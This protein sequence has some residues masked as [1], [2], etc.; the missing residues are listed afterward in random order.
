MNPT[1]DQGYWQNT[2]NR[3]KNGDREAF[4]IIYNEY[5]DLLY[6][7]GLKIT[8]NKEFVKD[9]IQDLFIDLYRYGKN[10]QTPISLEFYLFKSLK[11]LIIK[12]I[13]VKHRQVSFQ[14]YDS[15]AFEI[16]FNSEWEILQ[17]ESDRNRLSLLKNII[18]KLDPRKKE[19]L[20]LKFNSGLNYSEIG[21][22]VGLKPDTVKKQV[23]RLIDSLRDNYGTKLMELYVMCFQV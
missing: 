7:Y 15:S 5:V 12:K 2:W 8:P 18:K 20:Y 17:N 9:C 16:S 21:D 14:E 4:G 1:K 6:D 13:Q 23:Y 11:R 19:L 3:F 22:I 10:L